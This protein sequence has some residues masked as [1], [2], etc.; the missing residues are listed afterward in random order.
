LTDESIV[1]LTIPGM[2]F[3]NDITS[4]GVEYLYVTDWH[5]GGC[6][7]YRISTTDHTF[8]TFMAGGF[9]Y[10]NGI[11][12]DGDHN[13][14]LTVGYIGNDYS[15]DYLITIDL[16][17]PTITE[18]FDPGVRGF[19]GLTI[20]NDGNIYFSAWLPDAVYRYRGGELEGSPELVS[21]GHPDPADIFFDK[22][23]NILAVPNFSEHSVDF[24]LLQF[25]PTATGEIV[26]DGGS[27]QGVSWV[28]YDADEYPDI[29]VT[30]LFWPDGQNNWLYRNA[31]DGTFVRITDGAIV[32]DGGLSRTST[33]GDFDND[34]DP[35]AFV[36]NWPDQVNFLYENN[37]DGTFSKV[38]TGEIVTEVRGSPAAGWADY[39]N[40]GLL[41][42]FVAN[43]GVNSLFRNDGDGFTKIVEGDI[44]T[45]EFESYGVAWADYDSDGDQDLFVANPG[46]GNPDHNNYLYENMGDGTF[47]R[48]TEGAVVTDGGE[49]FGGSWGDCDNDGDLDLFVTNI[50]YETS[51]NNFLYR[52]NGDGTFQSEVEGPVVS[53]GGYSFGSA[54]GDYDN[55]GY[56]DLFVA[57]CPSSQGDRDFLYHNNGDGSF[58][59]ITDGVVVT[60]AGASY[61]VAWGDYD[62]DGDLDLFVARMGNDDEDNALF[63]NNGTLNSWITIT[64][65]GTL[66]NASAVGTVVSVKAAVTDVP[67]WQMREISAQ[68]G[69]CGQN[70]LSAHFGLGS[71][72]L[73]D[74]VTVDWPSGL[75][76]I[77]TD[78]AVDQFLTI[79]EGETVGIQDDS[80]N[81]A[82]SPVRLD[83]SGGYP[84]P[85]DHRTTIGFE[86]PA[87]SEVTL[88]VFNMKGDVVRVLIPGR[89][90]EPGQHAI[91]WDGTGDDGNAMS[92][93]KYF[94][95]LEAGDLIETQPMLLLR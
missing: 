29:F 34:G 15:Q 41:D 48:V 37:G 24:L 82:T 42:L 31:G 95:R 86:L 72:A 65:R 10:T 28:D 2:Q 49:S 93:G 54:W 14:L 36:A 33:W 19:D 75:V 68:T 32:N 1:D 57:N 88:A 77:M 78:V 21:S 58:T 6:E 76:D 16:D 85:F 71:A 30:N 67:I 25:S 11:L 61:G 27:T 46:E 87:P 20:D 39:N 5:P 18:T 90:L 73:V 92:S 55:D 50:S 12:Y 64:C 81:G 80:H 84:N 51:G 60:D 9:S 45:D 69:Y 23:N 74:S 91:V 40:D 17:D 3:L 47:S 56:L 83:L 13:R 66:S 7:I 38:V 70:S 44:A 59:K 4:D 43:Y 26:N 22:Y 89:M 94:C 53:D 8:S 63:H 35:D 52:N 62:R 79:R